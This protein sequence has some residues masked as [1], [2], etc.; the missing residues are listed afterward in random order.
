MNLQT[1]CEKNGGTALRGCP[2]LD[3]VAAAAGC[4]AATLYMIAKGHKNASAILA[5]RIEQATEGEVTRY[6][7]RPDVFGGPPTKPAEQGKQT[8]KQAVG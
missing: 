6:D 5:G 3:R 7:L 1:Y 4:S 8:S 2:V